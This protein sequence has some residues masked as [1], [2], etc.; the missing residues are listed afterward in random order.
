MGTARG[1]L[2]DGYWQVTIP[3]T[4][5]LKVEML[6]SV[7]DRRPARIPRNSLFSPRR[8][9]LGAGI[10]SLLNL[11]HRMPLYLG[12]LRSVYESFE[13]VYASCVHI[14]LRKT[15]HPLLRTLGRCRRG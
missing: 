5:T 7:G 11:T 9:D 8:K 12:V 3:T 1:W 4:A 10:N 6:E 2:W 13:D 15:E 14:R